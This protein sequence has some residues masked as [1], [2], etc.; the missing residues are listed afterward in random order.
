MASTSKILEVSNLDITENPF[1]LP[2]EPITDFNPTT[3]TPRNVQRN[4]MDY[5]DVE[6]NDHSSTAGEARRPFSSLK[7]A[8]RYNTTVDN[9][10]MDEPVTILFLRVIKDIAPRVL[11]L[12]GK[13]PFPNISD[14]AI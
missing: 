3:S 9:M 13:K 4:P 12:L 6:T 11:R 10:D 7:E 2:P 14:L 1:D 5:V 8:K